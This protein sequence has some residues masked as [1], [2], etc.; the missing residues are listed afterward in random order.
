M[1]LKTPILLLAGFVIYL[2]LTSAVL[3][4]Y[5]DDPEQMSWQDRETF[6]QKFISKLN[7]DSEFYQQ[8]IIERLGS[9][10][11]TFAKKNKDI[12]YQ[13]LYYRTQRSQPDGITTTDECTALLFKN[14][15]LIAKGDPAVIQ[16]QAITVD[17]DQR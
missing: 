9:P 16:F 5:K 2:L 10:D 4:F 8:N 14:R 13:V 17:G 15:R 11:I 7:V 3:L 6:N 1:K 12:V